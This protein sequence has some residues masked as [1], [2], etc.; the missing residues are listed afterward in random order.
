MLCN[1]RFDSLSSECCPDQ[2]VQAKIIAM[3]Q[4]INIQVFQD[5]SSRNLLLPTCAKHVK[6]HLLDRYKNT[7]KIK[8][9]VDYF[10]V[11]E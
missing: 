2:L 1:D 4:A 8:N 10:G 11:Y 5:S 6:T 3:R 9:G 7:S